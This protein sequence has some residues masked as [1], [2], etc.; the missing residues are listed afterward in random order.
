MIFLVKLQQF[1]HSLELH[2]NFQTSN[3]TLFIN[4]GMIKEKEQGE[5]S[6]EKSFTCR[7]LYN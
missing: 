2:E 1:S 5:D 4:Y 6:F 7:R 3:V